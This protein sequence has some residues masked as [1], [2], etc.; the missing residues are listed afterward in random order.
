MYQAKLYS[1]YNGLQKNDAKYVL[2]NYF[3]LVKWNGDLD[4]TV[5]DVGCGDGN[6]TIDL[7]LPLLPK[8]AEKLL[9]VDISKDMIK[10]A[11]D[12]NR[13]EKV[14]YDVM[15]V[16]GVLDDVHLLDGNCFQHIFS[17]YCLHWVQDQKQCFE[18]LYNLLDENGDLLITFL[19]RN[20]IFT[21]Y[22]NLSKNNR[23]AQYMKDV[24]K[25]L[26]PY[27]NLE[28]PEKE[29]HKVMADVGFK[30]KKCELVD[31]TF[32]FHDLETWKQS[33]IAINPFQAR[34]PEGLRKDYFEDIFDEVRKLNCIIRNE[35][36]NEE[37]I[38]TKYQL[39]VVYATKK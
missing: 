22:D 31:R 4:E 16:G 25:Y 11:R 24:K 7:L 8:N 15:D 20:P 35:N 12:N 34:I 37:K 33:V 29:L 5:L 32:I 6:V 21:V 14:E 23:W 3:N 9:G 10:F 39:L 28:D 19:A 1:N 30:V 2:D 38:E 36:N 26:S 13:R 18:N 27:H 17:F